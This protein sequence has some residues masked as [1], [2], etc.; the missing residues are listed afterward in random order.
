MNWLLRAVPLPVA[1]MKGTIAHI[2][3]VPEA[4]QLI[5]DDV[6]IIQQQK[7]S[8]AV[9]QLYELLIVYC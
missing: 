2:Q 5:C 6:A 9:G 8:R 3:M 4:I 1:E 7:P